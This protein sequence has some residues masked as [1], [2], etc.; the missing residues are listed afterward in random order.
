MIS[1][2]EYEELFDRQSRFKAWLGSRTSYRQ[3]EVPENC[4]ITNE[5]RSAIEVFQFCRDKL[6]I[7]FVYIAPPIPNSSMVEKHYV[8]ATTW[9]G[10]YLGRVYLGGEYTVHMPRGGKSVRQSITMHGINGV[11][12]YGTYYKSSGNYA[13]IYAVNRFKH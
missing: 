1:P 3:E 6:S 11:R 10:D 9:I 12:Y 4:R 8:H 5:E 7:Y 2:E 13:R